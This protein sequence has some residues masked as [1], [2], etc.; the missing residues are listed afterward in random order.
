[1]RGVVFVA[2]GDVIVMERQWWRWGAC[3]AEL[4]TVAEAPV[5]IRPVEENG[6]I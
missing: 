6:T 3:G 1:M 4:A 5:N 2:S